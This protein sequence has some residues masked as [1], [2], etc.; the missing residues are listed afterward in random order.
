MLPHAPVPLCLVLLCYLL[1]AHPVAW[2]QT[3]AVPMTA[4][5]WTVTGDAAYLPASASS[6]PVLQLKSGSADLKDLVFQDGTIDFDIGLVNHGI[7]GIKFR[8]QD[9]EN[10]DVFYIR[11][12]PNCQTSFD[13]IQYMPLEHGAFEWD[14]FPQFE[15]AAPI[16][17]NGWNHI[18]LVVSGRRLKVFVNNT[19]TP[20]LT[21][22]SM[23]GPA[24]SGSI[25]LHG[26]A[27]F[28]NLTIRP[29]AV[30]GPALISANASDR[31]FFRRWQVAPPSVLPTVTDSALKEQV[32]KAPSYHDMPPASAPWRAVSAKDTGLVN[33]SREVGSAKQGSTVSLAWLKTS[34]VSDRDQLKPASV[35]WVREIW[36]YVNG[37]L[38]YADRNLYGLPAASK[39]PDGRLSL[40]NGSFALPL[41]KGVNEIAIAL[42]DNLPGNTQH[43]GWGVELK[44][45][46]LAGIHL[47]D[48]PQANKTSASPSRSLS[49]TQ[50]VR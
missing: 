7:V 43:F 45:K 30:Q 16:A 4:D 41:K 32:G 10:A 13:C 8:Q 22:A 36:I 19:K 17:S 26:P 29:S 14:L 2:A 9:K 25:A 48:P 6:S 47:V 44:L 50:P 28:R 31:L 11:P 49:A 46:D 34:V 27:Y 38:V 3:I 1:L 5:R 42:D 40:E 12:Q 18:K 39:N 15:T 24:L 35:G 33:L 37:K 23:E 20:S 21:I